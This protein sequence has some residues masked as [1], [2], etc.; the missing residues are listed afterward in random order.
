MTRA[1]ND[2]TTGDTPLGLDLSG[3]LDD[4]VKALAVVR[5]EIAAL[6]TRANGL[7]ESIRVSVG[8]LGSYPCANG[9]TLTLSANR[10]FNM[11]RA[12]SYVTQPGNEPLAK[13]VQTYAIDRTLLETL[14]PEV[15][16]QCWDE[17]EPRVSVK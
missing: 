6:T 9:L 1:R 17:F 11:D 2:W 8:D 7:A 16:E 3:N 4:L 14:A 15:A 12:L 5:N 13:M 10:R